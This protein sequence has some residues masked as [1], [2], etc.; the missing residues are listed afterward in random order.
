MLGGSIDLESRINLTELPSTTSHPKKHQTKEH[1]VRRELHLLTRDKKFES[2][3][4]H[5]V[6][7]V[8]SPRLE[9][10]CDP[11]QIGINP[12]PNPADGT[13]SILEYTVVEK[14]SRSRNGTRCR[15][16]RR[17]VWW[18]WCCRPGRRCSTTGA[19]VRCSRE[20]RPASDDGDGSLLSIR[21]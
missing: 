17:C 12:V 2:F 15:L 14:P 3:G 5:S 10:F 13:V 16:C 8:R 7:K 20:R 9:L 11:E 21:C 1:V 19:W 18:V 6:L 4:T